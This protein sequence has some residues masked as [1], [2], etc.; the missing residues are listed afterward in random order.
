M[1]SNKCNNKMIVVKK[2]K[3]FV[4]LNICDIW[5][6]KCEDKMFK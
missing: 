2:G 4:F 6:L 3:L 1:N 5:I